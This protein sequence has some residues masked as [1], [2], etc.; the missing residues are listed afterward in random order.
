[1]LTLFQY[2]NLA[3]TGTSLTTGDQFQCYSAYQ[4]GPPL[5]NLYIQDIPLKSSVNILQFADDT[6]LYVTHNDPMNAQGKLNSYLVTLSDWF[7]NWKLL[8]NESKTEL[9]HI[10][11]QARDTNYKC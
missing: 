11:G 10:L 4:K 2:Q 8:L 6:T 3:K 5:F 7:K 1:M 9:I